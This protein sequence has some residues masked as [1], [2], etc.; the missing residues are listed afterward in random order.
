MKILI[1]GGAGFIGSHISK[2]LLNAGYEVVI[3]D[4]FSKGHQDLVPEKAK[5]IKANI[6]DENALAKALEGVESVIHMASW[7]EVPLSVTDPVGFANNNIMASIHLLQAMDKAG[8]KKIVFSSSA[9][10]YGNPKKLPLSENDPISSANPYAA[11]KVAVENFLTSY[12][13]TQGFDVTI[14]RYFNPYGPNEKHQPETHAIPNFIKAVLKDEPVPLY[15]KGEQVRDFI[16]VEDLAVAHINVLDLKGLNIFNVG[17]ES[18][19]KVID[20]VNTIYKILGK[21]PQIKDL[22]E[23]IGDVPANFASSQKLKNTTGWQA[24]YSP[25]EGLKKTIEWFRANNY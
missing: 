1:T 10:V 4:N 17:T 12:N 25:E 24:K 7:I 3:V 21:E 9:V 8:V 11:S 23:R 2:L 20:I 5:L 13:F 16:Y 6:A 18:G 14:L 19:T 15:W 22:G